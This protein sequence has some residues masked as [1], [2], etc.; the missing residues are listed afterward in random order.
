M[1]ECGAVFIGR[2]CVIIGL[3]YGG[4]WRGVLWYILL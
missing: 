2:Y 3:L 4:M 1:K